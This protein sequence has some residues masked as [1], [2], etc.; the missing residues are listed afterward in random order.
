MSGNFP[1]PVSGDISSGSLMASSPA[2]GVVQVTNLQVSLMS[3]VISG[4]PYLT[5]ADVPYTYT[6]APM[7]Y[8][9]HHMYLAGGNRLFLYTSGSLSGALIYQGVELSGLPEGAYYTPT[10]EASGLDSICFRCGAPVWQG[11]VTVMGCSGLYMQCCHAC[12]GF[13]YQKGGFHNRGDWIRESV[14]S[15]ATGLSDYALAD[16]LEEQGRI[17][18]AVYLRRRRPLNELKDSEKNS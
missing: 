12:A 1:I 13:D 5:Y 14:P 8:P 15:W 7:P 16:Y 9:R 2:S 11:S 10:V 18:D 4:L 17:K 3:G 6:H